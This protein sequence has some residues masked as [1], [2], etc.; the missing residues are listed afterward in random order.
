MKSEI[1]KLQKQFKLAAQ[2]R[3][4]MKPAR[5]KWTPSTAP[6]PFIAEPE[7]FLAMQKRTGLKY[8]GATAGRY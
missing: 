7:T 4:G 8:N 2:L 6:L 1:P 5:K 3:D